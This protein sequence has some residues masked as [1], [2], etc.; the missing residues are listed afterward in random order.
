MPTKNLSNKTM[1][2]IKLAAFMLA[3]IPL[4]K[5]CF[6]AYLDKLG[7]NPIEKISHITG[8]W[9][10][11]FLLITLT[12]TPLRRLSGWAWPVRLRRM[13]GLF[14]FFYGCLHF[15][16][17]LV[18][19]QFFDWDSIVKDIVKRPYIT[20]GFPAF[21]MMIP[22]AVTSTD[23]MIRR[24]GGKYWRMLHTLIY[25]SAIGGVVHYWWLV[26]KDL[27][28]PIIFAALLGVLLAIRVVYRLRTI[29]LFL[30]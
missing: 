2:R 30:S 5:L 10:L 25:P 29:T 6:S 27:T 28:N 18:L 21:V 3:L 19:D 20:V 17:Y 23:N 1:G 9:T 22:L 14:A 11:T 26:K 16:T 8:Y 15:L 13:L 7:A 4:F 24:L 12:P